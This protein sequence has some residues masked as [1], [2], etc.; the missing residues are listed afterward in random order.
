LATL[1]LLQKVD[2]ACETIMGQTVRGAS[3]TTII[4]EWE[5]TYLQ[6]AHSPVSL[7]WVWPL[8]VAW[9]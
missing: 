4:L 7:G 6:L 9:W 1:P 5:A 8:T 2:L 3:C